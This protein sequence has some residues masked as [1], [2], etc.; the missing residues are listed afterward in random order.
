MNWRSI[1][2]QVL[3]SRTEDILLKTAIVYYGDSFPEGLSL[4][5]GHNTWKAIGADAV[6]WPFVRANALTLSAGDLATMVAPPEMGETSGLMARD[7]IRDS[8]RYRNRS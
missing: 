2:K 1:P 4:L 3:E 7:V 6:E 8:R 5:T